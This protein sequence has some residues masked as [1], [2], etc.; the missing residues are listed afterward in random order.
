MRIARSWAGAVYDR[1]EVL[2]QGTQRGRA[3]GH[4]HLEVHVLSDEVE[5]CRVTRHREIDLGVAATGIKG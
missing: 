5:H 4:S 1:A 2:G 3:L